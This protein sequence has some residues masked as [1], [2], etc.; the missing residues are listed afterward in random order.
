VLRES[1]E[2]NDPDHP[3]NRNNLGLCGGM[4]PHDNSPGD[5]ECKVDGGGQG[6]GPNEG[7]RHGAEQPLRDEMYISTVQHTKSLF[8]AHP[9]K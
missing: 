8:S 4:I 2:R 7:E 9:K 5:C 3:W 1:P 6:G